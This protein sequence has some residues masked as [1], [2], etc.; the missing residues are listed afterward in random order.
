MNVAATFS[1][2]MR[3]AVSPYARRLAREKDIALDDLA[4]SGPRGRIVAADILAWRAPV[5]ENPPE[6]RAPAPT[7][8]TFTFAATVSLAS[9]YRLVADVARVGLTIE[10][11]D[12]VHRAARAALAATGHA[13]DADAA[14]IALEADGRQILVGMGAGL[15]IGTERKLRLAAL[16]GGADV[17]ADPAMLSLLVLRAARVVPASM[18]LLPGRRLRLVLVVN[19]ARE[20]ASALLCAEA[21]AI[22]EAHALEMLEAFVAALEQPLALMA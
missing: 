7:A 19:E 3:R 4:G 15:S 2:E 20:E 21:G 6:Q 13:G 5:V 22:A 16:E 17:S 14:G 10:V 9:L 8:S 1:A 11:E 12:A 18:P